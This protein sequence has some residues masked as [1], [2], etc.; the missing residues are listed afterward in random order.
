MLEGSPR[1]VL[2]VVDSSFQMKS[3]WRKVPDM[4]DALDDK[5]Y[6]QFG[7]VTEKGRVHGWRRALA[8]GPIVPYAPRDLESLSDGAAF[9]E[10]D[11][12][13]EIYFVTNAP[14]SELAAFSGWT[15]LRP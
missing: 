11:E 15:L 4:L 1:R 6:S 8:L 10:V 3:E 14:E 13:D 7:L 2:V 12:A 9:P 5:P